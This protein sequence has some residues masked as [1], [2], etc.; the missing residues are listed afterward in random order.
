MT[1]IRNGGSASAADIGGGRAK[2]NADADC[3]QETGQ[4]GRDEEADGQT[5]A[6]VGLANLSPR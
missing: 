1:G 3:R 4:G 6:Q 5:A 2:G